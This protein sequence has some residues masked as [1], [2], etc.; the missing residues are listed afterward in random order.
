LQRAKIRG[1]A[2]AGEWTHTH[3]HTQLSDSASNECVPDDGL[4]VGED[5]LDLILVIVV[6][7]E[8]NSEEDDQ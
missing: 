4:E 1:P 6:G 3:T 5:G 2:I 7:S 8:R